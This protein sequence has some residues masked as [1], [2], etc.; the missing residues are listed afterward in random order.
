M[1]RDEE[2]AVFAEYAVVLVFVSLT[3]AISVGAVGLPL[4]L[5]LTH[6][7]ALLTLPFP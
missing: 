1:L 7:E 6:A 2:G 4:F 5:H 3:V